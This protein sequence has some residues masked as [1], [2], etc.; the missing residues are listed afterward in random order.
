MQL[1]YSITSDCCIV[2]GTVFEISQPRLELL[3]CVRL[4]QK[5]WQKDIA[6]W[7]QKSCCTCQKYKLILDLHLTRYKALFKS[8]LAKSDLTPYARKMIF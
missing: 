8:V 5:N 7:G 3:L 1:V 6:K 2:Y 4:L